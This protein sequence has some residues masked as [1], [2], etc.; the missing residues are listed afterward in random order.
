MAANRA[1]TGQVP[2]MLAALLAARILS[3]SRRDE[4]KRSIPKTDVRQNLDAFSTVSARD[5]LAF[6]STSTAAVD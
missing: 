4:E 5:Q 3:S 6:R 1:S 2:A